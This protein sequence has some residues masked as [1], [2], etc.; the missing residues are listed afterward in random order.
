MFCAAI[1]TTVKDSLNEAL[2]S[3]QISMI[4]CEVAARTLEEAPAA[5]HVA[6]TLKLCQ[7]L[8]GALKEIFDSGEAVS[9]GVRQLRNSA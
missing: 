3:A 1:G 6:A 2:L 8:Q 7:Q 5:V 9:P 4:D